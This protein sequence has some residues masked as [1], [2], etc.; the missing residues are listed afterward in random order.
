MEE[1]KLQAVSKQAYTSVWLFHNNAFNNW[2]FS[3]LIHLLAERCDLLDALT[4]NIKLHAQVHIWN[5]SA[6]NK[7]KYQVEGY[8]QLVALLA[9]LR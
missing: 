1:I 4:S 5:K 3:P 2:S 7:E 8:F 9:L 6:S